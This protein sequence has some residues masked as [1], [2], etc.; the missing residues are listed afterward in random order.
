M[1]KLILLIIPIFTAFIFTGCASKKEN[2]KSQLQ[3]RSY[4]TKVFE[5]GDTKLVMKAVVDTLQDEGF[6]VKNANTDLGL[7]VATKEIDIES[8]AE[9]F[10]A[11]LFAGNYA[12]WKKVKQVEASVNISPYGKNSKVRVN[13]VIKLLDNHGNPLEIVQIQDPKYYQNFFSKVSKSLFLL[14]E[15][16]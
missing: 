13:F 7:V 2:V 8:K 14:K 9:A 5:I 1:K 4:Q 3:I 12:K 6:I 10:F 16:I 11:T 15:N